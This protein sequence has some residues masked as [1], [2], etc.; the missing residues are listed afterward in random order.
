MVWRLRKETRVRLNFLHL[1]RQNRII[2]AINFYQDATRQEITKVKPP[3]LPYDKPAICNDYILKDPVYIDRFC[4]NFLCNWVL[5][6]VD[7]DTNLL[8]NKLLR[9]E[10]LRPTK[11]TRSVSSHKSKPG[12]TTSKKKSCPKNK[13]FRNV[14][15][16][17]PEEPMSVKIQTYW[18]TESR[19]RE[20][21]VI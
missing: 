19:S 13:K 18:S 10:V 2:C 12:K 15:T 20:E 11:K 14:S 4:I 7:S 1:C 16:Q 17:L 8:D 21:T 9:K 5:N 6:Q 3:S